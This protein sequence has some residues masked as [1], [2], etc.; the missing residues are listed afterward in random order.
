MHNNRS[1]F[2]NKFSVTIVEYAHLNH[3]AIVK[4]IW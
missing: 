1:N 4:D 2:C 3:L